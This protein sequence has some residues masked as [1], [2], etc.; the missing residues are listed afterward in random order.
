MTDW[1]AETGLRVWNGLGSEFDLS[2]ALA[3]K[4]KPCSG[5]Q[6]WSCGEDQRKLLTGELSRSEGS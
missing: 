1:A 4:G 6:K 3:R 5:M 2:D